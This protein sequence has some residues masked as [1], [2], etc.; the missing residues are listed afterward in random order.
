MS[1]VLYYAHGTARV[2]YRYHDDNNYIKLVR[3]FL[4][5]VRWLV[6]AR[7]QNG[8][9]AVI[10]KIQCTSDSAMLRLSL[11]KDQQVVAEARSGVDEKT[12]YQSLGTCAPIDSKLPL[13]V[14]L[15]ANGAAP[16]STHYAFFS[17][18][19]HFYRVQGPEDPDKKKKK[20]GG[21]Y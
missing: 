21:G 18:F 10:A 4:K 12:S 2:S 17:D 19:V 6:F 7:E 3:E 11:N 5:D 16:D 1:S 15:M 9:P 13:H 8:E 20:K 14:G